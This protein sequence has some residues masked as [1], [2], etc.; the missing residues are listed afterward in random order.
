MH[1]YQAGLTTRYECDRTVRETTQFVRAT[2]YLIGILPAL[3]IQSIKT[4]GE[5]DY[6]SQAAVH[7]LRPSQRLQIRETAG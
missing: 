5:A 3:S 7:A 1:M 6:R 2:M 4:L